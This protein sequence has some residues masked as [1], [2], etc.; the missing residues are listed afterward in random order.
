MTEQENIRIAQEGYAAFVRGDIAAVL[1]FYTPDAIFISNGPAGVTPWVGTYKGH[2]EMMQ[3]FARLAESFE[4][5]SYTPEEYIAQGNKI[6]VVVRSVG[7]YKPTGK[8]IESNTV[9]IWTM[10]DGKI[11][12]FEIFDDNSTLLV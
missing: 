4:Y 5:E 2:D 7:T 12:R 3:F 11:T 9:H 1:G 10:Q 6:A 8:R